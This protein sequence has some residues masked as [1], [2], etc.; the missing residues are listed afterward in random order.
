MKISF[1]IFA[2]TWRSFLSPWFSPTVKYSSVPGMDKVVNMFC[3]LIPHSLSN[4]PWPWVGPYVDQAAQAQ[5]HC[6][7][8]HVRFKFT[9][10]F[11]IHCRCYIP[12]LS[13]NQFKWSTDLPLASI[14]IKFQDQATMGCSKYMIIL[15]ILVLSHGAKSTVHCN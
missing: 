7:C 11:S 4:C 5:S 10:L 3:I 14:A 15:F 2:R 6:F 8:R 13:P 9:C 12:S 1:R